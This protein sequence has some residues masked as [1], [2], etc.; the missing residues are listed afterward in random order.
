[1]I[2]PGDRVQLIGILRPRVNP[3]SYSTGGFDKYFMAYSVQSLTSVQNNT[4]FLPSDIEKFKLISQRNDLID[5]FV[6]SMAPSI[7]GHDFIKEGLLL[8]QLGGKEVKLEGASKIR[9]DVNVML[10]GDPGTGKSQFLRKVKELSP[11]CINSTGRGST[12]VGLTAAV[13]HD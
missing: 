9:G 13:I 5:L 7:H 1:M 3:G 10:I 6:R 8:Q 12:G 2:K 4:I 11:L